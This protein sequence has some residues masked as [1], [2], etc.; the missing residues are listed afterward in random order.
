MKSVRRESI[1]CLLI[2]T[3]RLISDTYELLDLKK[4]KVDNGLE[5]ENDVDLMLIFELYKENPK[6][7]LPV[8]T[9]EITLSVKILGKIRKRK[10]YVIMILIRKKMKL[11]LMLR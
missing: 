1:G 3:L 8:S 5:K 7:P 2:G 9:K 6:I 10:V 11:T 4:I